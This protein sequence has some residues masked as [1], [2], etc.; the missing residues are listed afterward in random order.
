M[1]KK[2]NSSPTS[3][4]ELKRIGYVRPEQK[5]VPEIAQEA[6]STNVGVLA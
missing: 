2:D 6:P 3:K 1:P 4:S 5:G